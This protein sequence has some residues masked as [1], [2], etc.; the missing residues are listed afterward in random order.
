M[1]QNQ[2][3]ENIDGVIAGLVDENREDVARVV[4]RLRPQ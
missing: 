4:E 3:P 1:S 2:K